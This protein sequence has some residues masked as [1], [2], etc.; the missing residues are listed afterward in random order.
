M[1]MKHWSLG[2]YI[3]LHFSNS[4]RCHLLSS[5]RHRAYG[6]GT[7][8]AASCCQAVR[9]W[10]KVST[11]RPSLWWRC[12]NLSWFLWV[13]F[14]CA[15][16]VQIYI[17]KW[18]W[19]IYLYCTAKK[20]RTRQL[21]WL[22]ALLFV[23][24]CN[25]RERWRPDERCLRGLSALRTCRWTGL[26]LGSLFH[27]FIYHWLLITIHSFLSIIYISTKIFVK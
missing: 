10:C 9:R 11:C 16:R 17:N 18:Y 14:C 3:R 21:G 7:R 20:I 19:E 22:E 24:N 6:V 26:V 15:L 25:E 8:W 2:V 23:C 27:L 5:D 13:S 4:I 1:V 12:G